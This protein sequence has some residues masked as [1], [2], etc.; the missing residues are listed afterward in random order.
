MSFLRWFSQNVTK[1]KLV[2]KDDSWFMKAINFFITLG[3]L[4]HICSIKDDPN[5]DRDE[6]F[7]GGYGTTIGTTVYDNPGW[8]WDMKPTPHI[9]HELTHA[10]Q[11]HGVWMALRYVF[12]VKWRM[13]YE[14]E[15]VQA[16]ILC[17]PDRSRDERW[18]ARRVKQFQGYG[19]SDES[20]IRRTLQAR[21]N[22]A[23]EG[24][25]RASARVVFEAYTTWSQ[26]YGS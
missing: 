3:N 26:E 9:V 23:A 13:F 6:S 15:A 11:S 14:S 5:T 18:M 10:V 25:P 20:L 24:N 8:N 4:L 2:D 21:L 19:V 17:F 22:E 1:I 7:M 12:D 16:E